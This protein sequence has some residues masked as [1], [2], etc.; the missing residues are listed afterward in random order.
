MV[1][2]LRDGWAH[3]AV[4]VGDPVHL[5]APLLPGERG[6]AHATVAHA[7]GLLIV[8]PDILLS[9]APVT[10]NHHLSTATGQPSSAW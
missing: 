7:G 2:H 10:G 1:A 3:S 4:E 8:H 6:G 9:G 5:L